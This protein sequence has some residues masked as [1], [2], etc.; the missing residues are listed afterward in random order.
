MAARPRS[1]SRRSRP[2]SPRP[3]TRPR[4]RAALAADLDRIVAAALDTAILAGLEPRRS[5]RSTSPAARPA[6]VLLAERLRQRVP[7]ARPVRGDRFASVASG[8]ALHAARRF[9]AAA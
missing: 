4:A 6:C 2:G 1:I 7:A 3:S 8:L 9:G 5:T